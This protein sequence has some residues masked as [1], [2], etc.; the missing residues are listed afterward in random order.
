MQKDLGRAWRQLV[1]WLVADVPPPISL[2]AEPDAGGNP[3]A[4]RL[5][6]KARDKEFKPLDGATVR[7]T[8]RPI[9]LLS[10]PGTPAAG[11]A[12]TTTEIQITAE[13]SAT[14][15]GT[16]EAAYIAREP[17]AYAAQAQVLRADG[18]P[19]GDAAT[20]WTS[21]PAAEEFHSLKPNRALLESI[22]R[23]T[24]GELVPLA[25]MDQF[26]RRLPSRPAPI[27]ETWSEPLWH[28][29]MVFLFVLGCLVAD[30]G[31]RRWKGLP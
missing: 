24:G 8:I 7:L 16:Y 19:A 6:V 28:Q 17:G 11:L 27:T 31:I 30:W 22:A 13:P 21:D 20:G 18:T 5:T 9:R 29:P 2:T 3:A 14:E 15:P 4:V 12:A 23:R 10:Q 25:E 26:V 1:R